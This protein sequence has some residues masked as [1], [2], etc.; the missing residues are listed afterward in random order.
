MLQGIV[1]HR[2][3][4]IHTVEGVEPI[5][6]LL[7][8]LDGEHVP[9]MG[10]RA[11]SDDLVPL[12]RS[13]EPHEASPARGRGELERRSAA[14]LLH[15][16][17]DE[18]VGGMH[19]VAEV[20]VGKNPSVLEIAIADMGFGHGTPGV[21]GGAL[22]RAR[23][24]SCRRGGCGGIGIVG[25][26]GWVGK[27]VADD[28]GGGGDHGGGVRGGRSGGGSGIVRHCREVFAVVTLVPRSIAGG[29]FYRVATLRDQVIHR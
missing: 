28:G 26:G 8:A 4:R 22:P 15:G 27:M 16:P 2:D 25:N 20:D 29:A 21:G 12:L 3:L 17:A 14:S 7:V 11:H 13:V 18:R 24:G 23:R 19:G 6:R 10:H 1:D 9:L 5:V